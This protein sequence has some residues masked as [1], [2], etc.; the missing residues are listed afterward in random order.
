MRQSLRETTEKYASVFRAVAADGKTKSAT[1]WTAYEEIPYNSPKT[2]VVIDKAVVK[3]GE[4]FTLKFE[5]YLISP[6]KQWQLRNSA[7]GE[8]VYSARQ[9]N[10][11]HHF[12]RRYWY[13]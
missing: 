13:L 9:C 12:I 5:D 3:P 6:A 10:K 7:T 11:H 2:D 1:S 8:F 4:T